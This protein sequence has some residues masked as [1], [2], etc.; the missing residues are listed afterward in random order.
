MSMMRVDDSES[1]SA[2]NAESAEEA[3]ERRIATIH[4]PNRDPMGKEESGGVGMD[5]RRAEMLAMIESFLGLDYDRL[6]VI[7]LLELQDLLHE[8]QGQL[9]QAYESRRLPPK[10]YV[11]RVNALLRQDLEACERLLGA[12]DFN[13]LFG[14]DI[15]EAQGYIDLEAFLSS[16][17]QRV[18]SPLFAERDL[19]PTRFRDKKTGF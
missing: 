13:R 5:A 17:A 4:G 2:E 14:C 8:R 9:L 19:R 15:D 6:K 11:A 18:G 7:R 3:F 12:E 1:A 16:E 10:Q